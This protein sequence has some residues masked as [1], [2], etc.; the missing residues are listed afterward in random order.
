MSKYL[1]ED[2]KHNNNGWCKQK[3]MN[4]LKKL[5]IQECEN[6]S[7]KGT[8]LILSKGVHDYLGQEIM[9]IKINDDAVEIPIIIMQ[10]FIN[11]ENI[12][13]QEIKIPD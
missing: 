1:C 7:R 9:T 11:G 8:F 4:G 2:C 6:F 3:R 10:E 12:K 5:N 13:E